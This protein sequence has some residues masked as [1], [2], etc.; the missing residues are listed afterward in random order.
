MAH[1]KQ[2]RTKLRQAYVFDQYS[3]EIAALNVGVSFATARRWKSEAKDSG[4]DWDKV[5]AAHVLA[6][7]S[8]EDLG[9]AILSGF[10]L[11]YNATIQ[12]LHTSELPA[13]KKVELLTSLADAF[14]KT[15]AASKKV[16]PETNQLATALTVVQKLGDFIQTH[17][18]KHLPAFAE[19][20]E[21]FG[22]VI[23]KE[24]G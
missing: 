1:P 23:Q 10:L 20:L 16:L 17:H 6:G 19:I 11:Q 22:A 4:D 15:T 12:E 18:P 9:R 7:D 5:R 14:N 21:P 13:A 24:F 3:L 8:M 2:T